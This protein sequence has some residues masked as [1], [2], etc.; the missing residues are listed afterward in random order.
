MHEFTA[1]HL[2]TWK[3]SGSGRVWQITGSPSLGIAVV[4]TK[5]PCWS[6]STVV[7]ETGTWTSCSSP[8]PNAACSS[9]FT[10]WGQDNRNHAF[11]FNRVVRFYTHTHT[12]QSGGGGFALFDRTVESGGNVERSAKSKWPWDRQ[13]CISFRN[14]CR[15]LNCVTSTLLKLIDN[16]N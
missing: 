7:A 13:A 14:M 15:L 5:L 9:M 3:P 8:K 10:T 2:C 11:W 1:V 12:H 4:S 16:I 6:A